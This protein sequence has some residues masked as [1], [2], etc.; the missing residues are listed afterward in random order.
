[1]QAEADKEAVL[2]KKIYKE[3]KAFA[4]ANNL[5]LKKPEQ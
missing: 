2:R 4:E 3:Q 5:D 1:M